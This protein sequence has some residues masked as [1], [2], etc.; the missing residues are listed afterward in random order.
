MGFQM[1]FETEAGD[2][3]AQSYWRVVQV[4]IGVADK[5]AHVVF[6]GYRNVV[7]KNNGKRHIGEKSYSISGNK[8]NDYFTAAKLDEKDPMA[9]GYQL[10][11]DTLDTGPDNDK[12]SFFDGALDV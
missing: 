3:Y 4:N 7:A 8:F 6:H 5:T 9:Q 10:A 11:K 12:K 2:T 1:P